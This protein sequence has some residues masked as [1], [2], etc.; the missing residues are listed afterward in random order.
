MNPRTV[1]LPNATPIGEAE[2]TRFSNDT[3]PMFTL[4]DDYKQQIQLALLAD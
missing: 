1:K 4:L 3:G 2:L